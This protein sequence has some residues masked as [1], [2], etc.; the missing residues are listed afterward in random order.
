MTPHAL[1]AK[2]DHWVFDLDN[3]LYPP[4]S[5]LFA[6]IDLAMTA[7][8]QTHLQLSEIEARALQKRYYHEHGATLGGL[9]AHHAI[10][11]AHFLE[12]VHD[13]DYAPIQPD[14]ALARLIQALPGKK[15]VFT[16]GSRDHAQRTMARLGI[17]QCFQGMFSIEDG[18]F[19]PKP[20]PLAF[21]RLQARFGFVPSKALLFDDLARNLAGAKA[22]GMHTV[23]VRASRNAAATGPEPSAG[24]DFVIDGL[25]DFLALLVSPTP[26]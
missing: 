1:L 20:S 8:V 7:Y 18:G 26:L 5:D 2:V 13:I 22:F 9:M 17:G 19:A 11:P 6:Q 24:A 23:L 25:H 16:N 12:A 10:D 4:E 14:A 3:T 21:E 15:L